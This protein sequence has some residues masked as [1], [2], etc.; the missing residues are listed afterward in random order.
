M[1]RKNI[2]IES[3]ISE[4]L[5][6]NYTGTSIW[7]LVN[8]LLRAF[9]ELHKGQPPQFHDRIKQAALSVKED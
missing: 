1:A 3:D 4:W 9:M 2:N 5:H 8:S 7:W 6:E